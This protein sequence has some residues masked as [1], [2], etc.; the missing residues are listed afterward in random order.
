MIMVEKFS[1]EANGYN[2]SEVNQFVSDVITQTEGIISSCQ[3]QK[4]EIIQLKAQLAHYKS[5]EDNLRVAVARAE[6]V[7]NDI[8]RMARYE[9]DEIIKQAKEDADII[10]NEALLRAARV[11]RNSLL[12][13][14]N[15]DIFKKKF[16]LIIE[17]QLKIA[18]E[19][20]VLELEP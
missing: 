16:R 12:L 10:V 20:E 4:E 11:E 1:Y 17:Q 8:K 18:D 15:I 14:K 3:S 9:S 6:A 19:I 5:I 7:G 13:E 2:R